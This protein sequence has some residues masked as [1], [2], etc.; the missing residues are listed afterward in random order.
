MCSPALGRD[1]HIQRPP[2]L[3]FQMADELIVSDPKILGG[4][5]C[6][7]GTRLSVEFILE[8]AASSAPQA[9]DDCMRPLDFPL[10]TTTSP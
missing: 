2:E 10:P 3:K 6:V 5:P 9:Q 8:L 4:K 1:D 7:R